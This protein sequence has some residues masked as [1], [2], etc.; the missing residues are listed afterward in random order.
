MWAKVLGLAFMIIIVNEVV[1]FI[2]RVAKSK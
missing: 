2:L 1:K